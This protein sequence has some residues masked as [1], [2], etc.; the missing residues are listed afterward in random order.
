VIHT[1]FAGLLVSGWV[2]VVKWECA[3]LRDH[4][5]CWL[6]VEV[7]ELAKRVRAKERSGCQILEA[8]SDCLRQTKPL[9]RIHLLGSWSPTD[10]TGTGAD[11]VHVIVPHLRLLL[12][13]NTC[14]LPEHHSYSVVFVSLS[15][16]THHGERYRRLGS[17]ATTSPSAGD[18][19]M[20]C[21]Y[22]VASK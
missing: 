14:T 1:I 16:L 6:S 4:E 8:F 21:S 5:F 22:A 3:R 18:S 15:T 11:D 10:F 13:K 20:A 7:C 12:L 9:A 17:T 2:R 19:G